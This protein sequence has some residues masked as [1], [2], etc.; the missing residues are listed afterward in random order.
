M[1]EIDFLILIDTWDVTK[2]TKCTPKARVTTRTNY[3]ILLNNLN[4][5]SFKNIV[6]SLG[7]LG[8]H[9]YENICEPFVLD[10][11]V[12][13][14]KPYYETEHATDLMDKWNSDTTFLVAGLSWHM[15]LHFR[16]MGFVQLNRNGYS[17]Y[18][19]PTLCIKYVE[20]EDGFTD[21]NDFIKD[22]YFDWDMSDSSLYQLKSL[23]RKTHS[24]INHYNYVRKI[25]A[26]SRKYGT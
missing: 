19:H 9:G 18:S 7:N 3:K 17:V 14:N 13:Q 8:D 20:S 4:L 10:W 16:E 12:N 26:E 5:F 6:V 15:C 21:D 1:K 24:H 22:R 2:L 23:K 25:L 11:V